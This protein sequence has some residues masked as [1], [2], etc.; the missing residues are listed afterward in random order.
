MGCVVW[1]RIGA[2]VDGV[3]DQLPALIVAPK[4]GADR[5][6]FTGDKLHDRIGSALLS[7][8]GIVITE[9]RAVDRHLLVTIRKRL[10]TGTES[11]PGCITHDLGRADTAIQPLLVGDPN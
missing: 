7:R 8:A 10:R 5:T 2:D 1:Q 4:E 9:R 3:Q 11:L 6:H